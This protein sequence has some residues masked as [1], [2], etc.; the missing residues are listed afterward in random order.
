MPRF[1]GASLDLKK[2]TDIG[3]S[4][5]PMTVSHNPLRVHCLCQSFKIVNLADQGDGFSRFAASAKLMFG[6]GG[7]CGVACGLQRVE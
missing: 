6:A 7:C 4:P 5:L 3:I 2:S 1:Q